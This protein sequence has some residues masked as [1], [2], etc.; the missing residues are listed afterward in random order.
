MINM[1]VSWRMY[2]IKEGYA[3]EYTYDLPYKYQ[4]EFKVAQQEAQALKKGLWNPSVCS[5]DNTPSN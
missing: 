2:L 4:A 3:Y 1:N 5:Q